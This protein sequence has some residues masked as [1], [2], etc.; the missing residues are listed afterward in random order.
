MLDKIK[1]FLDTS[2][3]SARLTELCDDVKNIGIGSLVGIIQGTAPDKTPIML[4]VH[5]DLPHFICS[6]VNGNGT[7]SLSPIGIPKADQFAN[8]T[9][10]SQEGHCGFILT[11][12]K[13][14]SA[15]VGDNTEVFRMGER[16][17]IK[18]KLITFSGNT[19]SSFGLSSAIP[20]AVLLTAAE[21][22][23]K[24]RPKRDVYL[25]FTDEGQYDYKQYFP[26]AMEMNAH[27]VICIGSVDS[28]AVD[29]EDKA[30]VRL[31]DRSFAA[32]KRLSDELIACGAA[33]AVLTEGSCAALRIQVN[34]IPCAQLDIPVRYI[35]SAHECVKLSGAQK[36]A[37][38]ICTFCRK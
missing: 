34:G 12:D 30:F 28:N 13:G 21:T 25:A 3:I 9:I 10:V 7:V 32:D 1:L 29:G 26:V 36:L 18:S 11:E 4:A 24:S 5:K 17:N 14:A 19:V 37:E 6:A 23:S 27:E 16:F 2:D 38:V 20:A 33:P 35:N 8:M 22:L 31:W 15:F